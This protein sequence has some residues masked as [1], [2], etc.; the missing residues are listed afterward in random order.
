MMNEDNDVFTAVD[1]KEILS[2]IQERAARGA[3][4]LSVKF[5]VGDVLYGYK[6]TGD[7]RMEANS[8]SESAIDFR[9]EVRIVMCKD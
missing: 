2:W 5:F 4:F 3:A 9:G 8:A 6:S 1:Q 7:G